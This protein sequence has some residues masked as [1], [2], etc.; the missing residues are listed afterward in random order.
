MIAAARPSVALN[1]EPASN[2]TAENEDHDK[3]KE[4]YADADEEETQL[5]TIFCEDIIKKYTTKSG[6]GT[7]APN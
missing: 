1:S 3:Y 4:E 5:S 2:S 6:S 7:D